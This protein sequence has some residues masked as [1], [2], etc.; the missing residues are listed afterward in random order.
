M[1]KTGIDEL[2]GIPTLDLRGAALTDYQL[3]V[4]RGFDLLLGGLVLILSLPIMGVVALAIWLIDGG[5]VLFVQKR[6]GENGRLFNMYKFRT[7]VINAEELQAQIDHEDENGNL[8]HKTVHDSR[9]TWLGYHLRRL[10]LDELPQ[11]LNVVMGT[12]SMVGPLSR[13]ALPC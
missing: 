11:L 1:Y 7:M 2:S 9:V 8:T 13:I 5:P 10:S 4:K 6:V 3:L 12:M